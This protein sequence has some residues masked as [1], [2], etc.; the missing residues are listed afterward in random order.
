MGYAGLHRFLLPFR[1]HIDRLPAPQRDAIR[2]TF[3]LITGPPADR[4]LVAL[5]VLT[6]LADVASEAPLVYAV[7]DAQWLD[8]ESAVVLGF[9]ARRLYAE[10]VVL[11]FVIR[12]PADQSLALSALPELAISALGDRDASELLSSVTSGQVS[13]HVGVRLVAATGGNPLALVELAKELSPA[14]LVGAAALPE[15][16]P[17]ADSLME[18]FG[19]RLNRLPPETQL[20][21]AV[22]AAEPTGTRTL[23]WR[24]A[25]QLGI[26]PEAAASADVS[27]LVEIGLHVTFRHP[28]VRSVAYHST[29]LHNGGSFI[30]RWHL[31]AIER[32]SQSRPFQARRARTQPRELPPGIR[33]CTVRR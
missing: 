18:V 2:S 22:A 19:R 32:R 27:H 13:A 6:L 10:R 4:F 11:V 1:S 8:P 30:G 26:D 15:P 31:R 24:A 25:E 23:L 7:D 20:I 21:L 14:Q 16:L 3:G 28:L 33:P 9:V 29:H 12:E 5:G 17:V